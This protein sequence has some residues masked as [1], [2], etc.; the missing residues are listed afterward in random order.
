MGISQIALFLIAVTIFYIF[1][2]KLFSGDYPKR[3]IDYEAKLPDEQIGGISRP[4]K[5]FAEPKVEKSRLDNLLEMAD[6][7]LTKEDFEDAKKAILSAL[8]LDENNVEVLQR[9]GFVSIQEED[10][11]Q[12]VVYYEKIIAL[13]PKN[14]LA[15]GSLANAYHKLGQDDKAIEAHKRAISLDAHYAPHFFNYANTLY[16]LGK[17]DE[18]KQNYQKTLELDDG[19]EEAQAMIDKIDSKEA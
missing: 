8:I 9:A 10:F 11:N 12:A 17:F 13:E 7:S 1:F 15:L 5:I 4:D 16:D 18:A 14:D 6:D 2:K 19:L 3:G